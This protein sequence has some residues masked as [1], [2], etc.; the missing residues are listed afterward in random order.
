MKMWERIFRCHWLL[1]LQIHTWP[2]LCKEEDRVP[3][4]FGCNWWR[5]SLGICSTDLVGGLLVGFVMREAHF[6]TIFF[7][8]IFLWGSHVWSFF[9]ELY[10]DWIVNFEM[11]NKSLC[12]SLDAE[13]EGYPLF[14]NFYLFRHFVYCLFSPTA[15]AWGAWFNLCCR[16]KLGRWFVA[17]RC[18]DAHICSRPIASIQNLF[19]SLHVL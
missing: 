5:W 9:V 10:C 13:L 1:G 11:I 18:G 17:Q 14:S 7:N 3:T 4:V 8:L 19:W 6:P 2:L 12:A 15:L 16:S